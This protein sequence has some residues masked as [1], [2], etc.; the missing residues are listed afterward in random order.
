M[1]TGNR[2]K[3]SGEPR[4]RPSRSG[5]PTLLTA[6]LTAELCGLI[7]LGVPAEHAAN[8]VGISSSIYY[9]WRRR[10]RAAVSGDAD[11]AGDDACREFFTA[12]EQAKV[13]VAKAAYDL[14]VRAA[15]PHV[16]RTIVRTR[17]PVHNSNGLVL[18]GNGK[19]LMA[20]TIVIEDRE[21]D[22]WR[23]ADALLRRSDRFLAAELSPGDADDT[24]QW[25]EVMEQEERLSASLAAALPRLQA[26]LAA[27]TTSGD[28]VL[29]GGSPPLPLRTDDDEFDY[30]YAQW[31]PQGNPH[32]WP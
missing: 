21:C 28:D 14:L 10:G 17:S 4:T 12:T 5:R 24:K 18:D 32:T 2:E 29:G 27:G 8:A 23:A 7:G 22:E 25:F 6:E 31:C 9:E 1:T 26:Q 19:P 3:S 20:E 30:I 16:R 15:T 13:G 11:H